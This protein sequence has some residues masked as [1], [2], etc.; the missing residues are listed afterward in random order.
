MNNKGNTSKSL[1]LLSLIGF[2]TC[3]LNHKSITFLSNLS[4]ILA[5]G[6]GI[7]RIMAEVFI[8]MNRLL[9][10]NGIVHTNMK[11]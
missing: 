3:K 1:L 11:K 10:R 8:C 6:F 2:N 9:N 7:V 5:Y 4:C